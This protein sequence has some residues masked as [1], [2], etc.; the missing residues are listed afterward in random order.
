MRL[1]KTDPKKIFDENAWEGNTIKSRQDT[2]AWV[3]AKKFLRDVWNTAEFDIAKEAGA[4]EIDN[5]DELMAN[6]ESTMK[7][8]PITVT[9]SKGVN[10]K[11]VSN[12]QTD[13]EQGNKEPEK[14]KETG[15][16]PVVNKLFLSKGICKTNYDSNL[17]NTAHT[18][19]HKYYIK[20]KLPKVTNKD[21]TEAE[22]EVVKAFVAMIQRFFHLDSRA[23][24]LPWNDK[25]H[26]KPI[27]EGKTL[28]KSRDQM[29]HYV[30]RVFIQH[31][32]A[33]YCRI[34]VSFDI[35]ED[36]FFSNTDWFSGRGC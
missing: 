25:K 6:E 2:I 22:A 5:E 3:A 9:P 32:K 8:Q 33:A 35:D 28:P 26:V 1:C 18:R 10:W 11:L 13:K 15:A 24:I 36:Q 27:T 19:K 20:T 21:D 23:V 17:G 7:G 14:Q 31:N 34:K 12:K 4:M 30:N 16:K 29:E